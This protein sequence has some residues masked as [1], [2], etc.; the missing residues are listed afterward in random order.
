MTRRSFLLSTGACA[1]GQSVQT[2]SEIRGKKIIDDALA[3][4]GGNA[5]LTMAD[6]TET[7]R[8]YSYYHDQ[9]SG[10]SI[11][12]IYNA[13]DRGTYTGSFTRTGNRTADLKCRVTSILCKSRT[14]KRAK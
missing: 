1:L 8:A 10:L 6:R 9:I 11:A 5:F 3:A 14:W 4:L 7:G 12:K 13:S 2:K